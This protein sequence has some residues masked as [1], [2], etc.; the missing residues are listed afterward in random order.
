MGKI[1]ERVNYP[2]DLK[3]LSQAELIQLSAE[4][5]EHV[6][7]E[8]TRIGGHLAASLGVVE[9]TVAMH[10]AFNT[11]HDKIIW[12]VSHQAYIHKLLTGR[13]DRFHTIRMTDGLSGFCKTEE[14]EYDAF[15]TGHAST[16]ISAAVGMAVARDRQKQ[17]HKV[18]AVIGDGALTGGLA[19]EAMNHAGSIKTDM[20]VILNDNMMS[21]SSNVGALSK[22]LTDL[23]SNPMYN[24]VKKEI[25][26]ALGR[27]QRI[28]DK[29]RQR[30]SKLEE[31]IKTILVPG[32]FFE[33][34]GFRYF[35]PIDG[36]DLPRLLRL[37]QDIKTLKGPILIHVLTRKGKGMIQNE[38]DIE[39]YKNDA[40]KYH[41]VN[42]PVRKNEK[43]EPHQTTVPTYTEIF[44]RSLVELCR[45]NRQI[46][47]ITAAMADGTGLKYL[48]EAMPE[49]Y[50]DVGIAESHAVTM[51]AGMG[52]NGL[53]P[54]VAIYSSFM[55]RAYDQL[56]HDVALQ[57]I[58]V[59]FVLDR[60]GL[61]G[62]DGPTHHGTFDLS[63]LRC[64]PHLVVMAP[65]DE[66]E[67]RNMLYTAVRYQAGP[68]VIRFPRGQGT[69]VPVDRTFSELEIGRAEII[70]QGKGVAIIS[71][72]TMA[73]TALKSAELLQKSDIL[74]TIVNARF[75]KPL[76]EDMIFQL[77]QNHDLIVTLEDNVLSGGFGSAVIET[78]YSQD[79]LNRYLGRDDHL[80]E[81]IARLIIRRFG[82][83]D[84]FVEHGENP[85][86]YQRL[87][88]DPESI[89]H[90]VEETVFNRHG[91]KALFDTSSSPM[92]ANVMNK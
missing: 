2:Q 44:G 30:V 46:V 9:L 18:I 83:P 42:P 25:W 4:L 89:A 24:K 88:L 31:G 50:Y 49:R 28:G 39:A 91:L 1:F 66:N 32:H 14:S 15:G 77:V 27:F 22:H 76:D 90:A 60:A 81:K 13:K 72:G 23:I 51:A 7:R 45:E 86:L 87:G 52:L 59:V 53:K 40:N 73:N 3:P 35:G 69:G 33:S 43:F 41:A 5:R 54:V 8:I 10:H 63:F 16:S 12:D 68:V 70:A 19:F 74:P 29:V 11:P 58:P 48:A 78:V 79:F 6:I 36:H 92:A 56:I 67:L 75:V 20:I 62:A 55:Q 17:S 64:V 34:L 71:A 26:D 21:I 84:H 47:G 80:N 57:K 61:V 38:Q 82:L 37:F 65:R 85:I